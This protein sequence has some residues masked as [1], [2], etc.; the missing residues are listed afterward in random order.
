[1]TII[2]ITQPHITKYMKTISNNKNIIV[3][4]IYIASV[5]WLGGIFYNR[6]AL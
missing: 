4:N 1:M 6:F 3:K 2:F 5:V